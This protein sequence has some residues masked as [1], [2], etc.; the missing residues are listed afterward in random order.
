MRDL[1]HRHRAGQRLGDA[2]E[3]SG[4]VNR[5]LGRLSGLPLARQQLVVLLGSQP[6]R[7]ASR[8]IATAA[9]ICPPATSSSSPSLSVKHAGHSSTPRAPHQPAIRRERFSNDGGN[10]RSAK[11]LR[12]LAQAPEAPES[13]SVR[14]PASAPELRNSEAARR[15]GIERPGSIR[16]SRLQQRLHLGASTGRACHLEDTS[17][18]HQ[19]QHRPCYPERLLEQHQR[20]IRNLVGPRGYGQ[21]LWRRASAASAP[22]SGGRAL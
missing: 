13:I 22:S 15:N 8:M 10:A 14:R 20:S 7:V 16:P 5:P 19:L 6:S 9:A 17:R 11:R 4:S 1:K 18:I 21:P 3:A 2:L 12:E